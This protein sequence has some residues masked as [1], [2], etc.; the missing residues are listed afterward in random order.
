MLHDSNGYTRKHG[1]KGRLLNPRYSQIRLRLVQEVEALL[2]VFR[3]VYNPPIRGCA[4]DTSHRS[5]ENI[6]P[7]PAFQA[8]STIQVIEPEVDNASCSQDNDLPT[9][10]ERESELELFSPVPA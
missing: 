7:L 5:L 1:Q 2:S 4:N 8:T 3:E 6:H 10:Q 9:L